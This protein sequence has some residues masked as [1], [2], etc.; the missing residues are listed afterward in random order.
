MTRRFLAILGIGVFASATAVAQE[1]QAP[2]ATQDTAT[3]EEQI[4]R[5]EVVVV[6][7]SKIESTLTNAP[8][9]MSVVT[10]DTIQSSPAQNYGDL[11]RSVPGLNVIQMSNRDINLTSRQ[12]TNTLSNSQLALL[13]G[14]SIYLDFFGLILWDLVPTNTAEI[15]QIEVVRGPASAVWGANALTGVVNI[16]TKSPRELAA[17]AGNSL[18][19]SGGIFDRDVEGAQTQ[20]DSGTSYG[21]SGSIA[22]APNDRWSYK[23]SAGYFSSDPFARPF[24]PPLSIPVISDPRDPATPCN[25]PAQTAGCIGGSSLPPYSN[26]STSQPKLDIRADQD[27]ASGARI[28]YAAGFAGTEGIVHS[29]IGPFDLQSGSYLGYGKVNYSKGALKLNAFVN[30]LDAEA[31]NLLTGDV[32]TGRP[33]QLN[34]KTQTFDLEVGHNAV[35]GGKHIL[36]Y[37]GNARRNNFDI[38]ITPRGEDRNEFGAYFQEEFFLEKFRLVVGARVDKFGN[39]DDPVFSPRLSA[40]F[41]P[42]PSHAFR[43]SYNKAFRSPS[44]IN[45][46]IDVTIDLARDAQGRPVRF[47]L[48][49]VCGRAAGVVAP[50]VPM[51]PALRLQI[52]GVCVP[53]RFFPT[54]TIPLGTRLI[55]N[56]NLKEES[57]T[58]YEVGYTGNFGGKTTVGAAFYINDNDDNI[59]F[60]TSPGPILSSGLQYLYNSKNPPPGWPFPVAALDDPVLQSLAFGR[61]PATFTYLNLGPIRNK[62]LE[63]SIDHVINNDVNVFANYSWQG[64]PKPLTADSDQIPYPSEEIGFPPES[65]FNVGVNFNANRFMGS[66]S[67]SYS[68]KALWSDVLTPNFHGFTDSYTLVNATFGVKWADGK[69]T[70]SLKCMNLT[71]EQIQQHIF[72]DILKRSLSLE[73]RFN[74]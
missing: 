16:I 24:P 8:A 65:R 64:R 42:A 72:G 69:V 10:S 46:F 59:N 23:I 62:G 25:P 40:L 68:D 32:I 58:A 70:T 73:A 60:I 31:P 22:R 52:L 56:E 21:M 12:G 66:A 57:I 47:P 43:I 51:D 18:T 28:T 27:L 1:A 17:Q 55:G 41:K 67:L 37:G 74:F 44:V 63:L 6:T 35:V 15:K 5:E 20:L 54:Q 39:L 19:L 36:S 50:T 26:S 38:T 3:E 61:V 13:D 11:L 71:N 29:G 45:N 4:K 48:A 14:R 30:Y 34:F 9:T 49:A 7:A 2:A 53:N 33:V